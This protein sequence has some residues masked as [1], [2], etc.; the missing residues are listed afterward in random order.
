MQS[1]QVARPTV[2]RTG[3]AGGK[4]KRVRT[5]CLTCRER[6]LKCDEGL[7]TCMNC[8]KSGRECKRGV[9]LNFIDTQCQAPPLVAPREDWNI[10]F[11]DDS[12]EIASDYQDGLARYAVVDQD[13]TTHVDDAMSYE[14][15]NGIPNAPALAHQSLPSMQGIGPGGHQADANSDYFTDVKQQSQ[16]HQSTSQQEPSHFRHPSMAMHQQSYEQ[17]DGHGQPQDEQSGP[18]DLLNTAEETLYMQVFV[19][20]VGAWMDSMDSMK[21]VS[22]IVPPSRLLCAL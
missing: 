21:H 7:P 11:Q 13:P 20:E 16:Q 15:T 12:R 6:H 2:A 4:P 19:E 17:Q 14:I 9:R 3:A 10:E 8:R 18:R 5:G 1:E 22:T